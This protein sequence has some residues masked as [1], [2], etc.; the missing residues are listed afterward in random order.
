MSPARLADE[1]LAAG[2]I[3][4]EVWDKAFVAGVTN[5]EKIR[6]MIDVIIVKMELNASKYYKKFIDI[7]KQIGGALEDVVEFIQSP[8][9]SISFGKLSDNYSVYLK[10]LQSF[11]Q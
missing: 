6:P 11:T 7:L 8:K 4:G 1:L 10:K 5:S 3:N 9:L 2:L